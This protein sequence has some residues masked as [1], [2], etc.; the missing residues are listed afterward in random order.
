MKALAPIERLRHNILFEN[1]AQKEFN[2]LKRLFR[3]R[4]YTAG[5]VILQDE[6]EGDE[7]FLIVEGRVKIVKRTKTGEE[8]MLALLHAGDFFGELEMVDGRPRSA[9]VTAL[10]D[11]VTFTLHRKEFDRLLSASH[12]FAVRLMQVLS[13]RLRALNNHFVLELERNARRFQHELKKSEQLLEATKSLNSTL[14]LDK[15]LDIILE[16]AL[17]IVDGERGTVYLVDHAKDE[18]WSRVLKADETERI[19]L[20]MGKGIAGYVGSTGDTLNITDAYM[21]PRF[22]PDV[23]RKTGYRTRSILCMPMKNKDGIIIGVFQL[24]NKRSGVFTREDES[25]LAGLSVHAAIAIENARLYEQEKALMRMREEVRLAAAI[26]HELLPKKFPSLRGYDIAGRSIPAQLVGGDY[27]DFI[28]MEHD[29]LAICLGD[30]S[31]KGLP[32]ALLMSNVQATLRGQTLLNSSVSECIG[33]SNTLIYRSTSDERFVTLF[34][35]VLD[36]VRHRLTFSNA[37]HDRPFLLTKNKKVQRLKTGGIVLGVMEKFPFEE[38][39][40]TLGEDDLLVIYSDGIAEAMNEREE[41]FG[42]EQIER[43]IRKHRK[44]TAAEIIDH[45]VAAARA[46]AGK[47]P[48]SDDMT[49][50]VLKRTVR[51]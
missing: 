46:H 19:V 27:Y 9:T 6:S 7:M 39:T 50:V 35:A 2:L 44:G 45:I 21:D 40:I 49:I 42:E 16:T 48:Q 51:E 18:L 34:C 5:K 15:L 20:P 31:G 3:E 43:V 11:C 14:E 47:Y 26:Q 1:F 8:K 24:L 32:A 22:N 33:R 38:E 28:P 12:P 37:G 10:D 30:V 36:P 13:I 25:V 41:L 23:D 17:R 29:R 4:R